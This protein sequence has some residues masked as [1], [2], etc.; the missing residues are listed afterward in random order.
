MPA[1]LFASALIPH[2]LRFVREQ[3]GVTLEKVAKKLHLSDRTLQRRLQEDGL[4][5]AALVEELRQDTVKA[6]LSAGELSLSEVAVKVGYTDGATFARAFKRWTGVT[7][8]AFRSK[9]TRGLA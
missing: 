1:P 3:G 5:F 9:K 4:N 2:A 8:G 6:L 7:P